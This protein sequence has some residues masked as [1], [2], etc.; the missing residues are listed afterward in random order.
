MICMIEMIAEFDISGSQ[1]AQG[2]PKKRPTFDLITFEATVLTRSTFIFSESSYFH[3]KFVYSNP[4]SVES[5][6][7]LATRS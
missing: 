3:L 6:R 1:V 4:K 5:C 2:V 7:A